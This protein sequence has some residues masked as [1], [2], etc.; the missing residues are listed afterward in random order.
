MNILWL[1]WKDYTHPEA[2]GAEVVL[3][4]L[5]H[6]LVADGHAV[7][8]LTSRHPGSLA[9]ETLDGI[10]VIRVG[11]N[12]YLHSFQ[13]LAHYLRHMRNEYDAVI[14]EINTA[15][16][17]ASL[18]KTTAKRFVFYHQLAREVWF[19]EL[20]K[21]FSTFG[22]SI[23]EPM[24]TRLMS[25]ANAHLI[26]V[27]DSS[28]ADLERFG[29]KRHKAHI[30][31]EGI[32]IEP[33]KKLSDVHKFD[34]PTMLS[35]GAIRG[36]KR[37]LHQVKAFEI[38]KQSIP[39]L[40]LIVAGSTDGAYAQEVLAYIGES[41]YRQDIH[42][43]GKVSFERKIELMQRAHVFTVTSVKEGWGLVVTE[44]ASQGTPAVVYDV[45]GLRDSVRQDQ[46]GIITGT[47]PAALAAGIIRLLRDPQTYRRLRQQAWEWSK[48]ITFDKSYT[49]FKTALEAV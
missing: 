16:Y 18:F 10:R 13:A 14:E 22:Y 11:S 38:A 46:T 21:P 15:P 45:D 7:T 9:Q 29:F 35:L 42:I 39:E 31:S 26:T 1:T 8:Y 28:L 41:P 23:M 19:H 37:T 33:I 44:A 27:S 24:A 25:K 48:H 47:N 2:G 36:M 6:R 40:N 30:I 20:K 49:D 34:K 43:E 12:R 3:R 17:F 4:E 5:S 32:E